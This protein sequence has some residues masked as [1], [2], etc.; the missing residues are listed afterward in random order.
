MDTRSFPTSSESADI[1]VIGGGQAG[2]ALGYYLARAERNFVILDAGSRVGDGWRSR[3]DSLRLFTPAK[4]DG[5]P[6]MPFPGDRL[7]FPTKD[8]Q[9]DYLEAYATRFALPVRTGIRVD[10]VRRD[11]D[12]FLVEAGEPAVAGEQRRARDRRGAGAVRAGVRRSASPS[13]S[14]SCT[15]ALTATRTSCVPARSSS[16]GS[17]TPARRSR[18]S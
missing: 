9:A 18:S 8:E 7:A 1:V 12:E 2:L 17:G 4:Y 13:R 5:L 6:G 3:W 15:P 14:C 16:S 10:R 11:G